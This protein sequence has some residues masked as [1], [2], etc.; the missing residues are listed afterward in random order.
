MK[1]I[2]MGTSYTYSN[3]LTQYA[4]QI[5]YIPNSTAKPMRKHFSTDIFPVWVRMNVILCAHAG[6]V[7]HVKYGHNRTIVAH[8][9]TRVLNGGLVHMTVKFISAAYVLHAW[10]IPQ[11]SKYPV[12]QVAAY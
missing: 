5:I 8:T 7:K 12:K 4:T 11:I 6:I 9:H 10:H 2:P 3:A 1:L